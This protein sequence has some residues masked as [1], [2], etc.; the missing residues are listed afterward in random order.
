M[1]SYLKQLKLIFTPK[2]RAYESL[3][4]F[5]K[6]GSI[7]PDVWDWHAFWNMTAFISIILA[8]MNLL[9]IPGLDGGHVMFVVFEIV[10]RRKPNEKFM[11]YAQI[12]GM[13][14][15]F[16]IVIYANANDI[17]KLFR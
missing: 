10:T 11:E 7:F 16:A 6:I 15:L 5:I 9:P 3:G 1:I 4:G 17:L 8:V 12:A 2:T 13:I 14:L